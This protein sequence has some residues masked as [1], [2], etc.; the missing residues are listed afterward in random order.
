MADRYWRGGTGTWNTTSTTNWS[1]TSGGAGGASVPTAADNVIF[2]QATTYTVTMTGAIRCLSFTVSAGVV[3]FATGTTPTLAISGSMSLVAATVWNSTGTITFNS[4]TARTITTNGVIIRGAI[5]L[6]GVGGVWSLGSTLT[7]NRTVLTLTAGSFALNGFDA[8]VGTFSSSNTNTRSIAFGSNNIYLNLLVSG[9]GI[10]MNTA[11]NF[12]WTGTTGNEGFIADSTQTRSYAFGGT[13]GGSNANA[14]NL[15]I[16]TGTFVISLTTNS[17]WN[18]LN[19]G[20]A[21]FT[22]TNPITNNVKNL[23]LSPNGNYTAHT[24]NIR[25]GGTIIFNGA[26]LGPLIISGTGT[27]TMGDAG[28]CTTFNHSG[29]PTLDLAGF[30]F[31]AT[32]TITLT[33]NLTF[34]NLADFGTTG[35]FDI[36]GRTFNLA[37][38]QTLRAGNVFDITNTTI[39]LST[40]GNL[41]VDNIQINAGSSIDAAGSGTF[42]C[43]SGINFDGISLNLTKSIDIGGGFGHRTGT[44]TLGD[45]VTLTTTRYDGFNA[46]TRTVVFGS[47]TPGNINVTGSVGGILILDMSNWSYSGPGGFVVDASVARTYSLGTTLGGTS[48]NAPRLT[49]TTGAVAPTITTGSWFNTLDFGST[50][51]TIAATALNLNGL[52]LSTGGTFTNLTATMVGTGTITSNGKTIAALTVNTT[53]TATLAGALTASGALTLTQGTLACSTFSV[54]SATFASTGTLTRSMSG[55]GTYTITGAG[56]TAF[57]NASAAGITITGLIIS[58]TAATAKTFAGGGGSFSTLNQG[59]A[60]ALTISGNN[61]FSDLTATTRPSTITFT[62]SSTQTFA[63]FTLSGTA[64]NLVTINSSTAGTQATLSKSSG[65]VSV[66]FLSIRDSNATGGAE[67]YADATST[68]VSNNLGWIFTAPPGLGNSGMFLM[69]N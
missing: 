13:A 67:W 11:T 59:G 43:T 33:Y 55:S 52:T 12:S 14:I 36:T 19:F 22:L 23:T 65:T 37:T 18:N 45:G 34:V 26:Q 41:I 39:D 51:F 30:T 38:G 6:N 5:T 31:L 21:T 17:W 50:A 32:G 24:W 20:T 28:A 66:G 10:V 54:T 60:G 3:T 27:I 1:A 61:S 49:F 35:R 62:A 9:Q 29:T 42:T 57:S 4:T 58:M 63:D 7:L 25:A 15:T 68:N 2:N 16:T 56:A 44:L 53:G 40:G 8:T 69:F 47:S 64:G 48:T 46:L